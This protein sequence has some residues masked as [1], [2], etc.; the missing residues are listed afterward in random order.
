LEVDDSQHGAAIAND[1]K[2][3]QQSL[4][5]ST[6]QQLMFKEPYIRIVEHPYVHI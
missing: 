5:L 1:Q 6:E 2:F 3:D 4:T